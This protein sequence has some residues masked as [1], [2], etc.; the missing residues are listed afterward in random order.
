M[1]KLN[2]IDIKYPYPIPINKLLNPDY[3]ETEN[4]IELIPE[5]KEIEKILSSR[6]IGNSSLNITYENGTNYQKENKNTKK[7]LLTNRGYFNNK[8]I[9]VS[10]YQL[11]QY[12]FDMYMI[13]SLNLN[14]GNKSIATIT[15]KFTMENNKLENNKSENNIIISIDSKTNK[16]YEDKKYNKLLR[17]LSILVIYYFYN[18]QIMKTVGISNIFIESIAINPISLHLLLQMGFKIY[19]DGKFNNAQTDKLRSLNRNSLKQL[20]KNDFIIVRK[21]INT[22]TTE[23]IAEIIK[24]I[25]LLIIG[26]NK[27]NR[28]KTIKCINNNNNKFNNLHTKNNKLNN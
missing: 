16:I 27:N 12:N 10:I 3:T 26:K 9:P 14:E 13:L 25:K 22:M 15:H 8:T 7:K 5:L 23:D 24:S 4:F 21:Q 28:N 1:S 18:K 11:I 20:V 6:C 17:F 2:N 19:K